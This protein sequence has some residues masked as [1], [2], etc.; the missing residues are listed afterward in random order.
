MTNEILSTRYGVAIGLVK[1]KEIYLSRRAEVVMFPKKWQFVNG[2]MRGAELSR[3]AA[4]RIIESET[5]IVINKERLHDTGTLTVDESGEFYYVYLVH[6]NEGECPSISSET[7]HGAWRAFPLP[8]AVVLDLVPGLRKV[9][10]GLYRAL[11]TV[12]FDA[13]DLTWQEKANQM[14]AKQE[15]RRKKDA[16]LTAEEMAEANAVFD[17]QQKQEAMTQ[18]ALAEAYGCGC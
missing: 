6:L 12:E 8:S 16:V 1:D 18:E 5:G 13:K 14:M 3:D 11:T 15:S 2:R 9:L 10:R 7:F 17:E 4:V